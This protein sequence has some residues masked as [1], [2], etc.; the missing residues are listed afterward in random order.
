[1]NL[2]SD[3]NCLIVTDS[4]LKL[5][6]E[7]LL[8]NSLNITKNSKLILTSIP[9]AHGTEPPKRIADE[10]LNYDVVLLA[11]TKSLSHT[12]AR[13]NASKKGARMASMPGITQEMMNRTLNVDFN[14]IRKLNNKLIAKLK[15]KNKIR[16]TTKK[17]TSMVFYLK[18]RK[19]TGDDGIYTKKGSFGNLPA[20]EVF[21]AP[22]ERKSSGKIIVDA[23]I[24]G[25]GKVD[26]NAEL[27]V[28]D[29]FI[30][31]IYGG[32][33]AGKFK[34]L[35][36]GKLYRNVAELGIGTNY[37]ARITGNVLEDEKVAGTCHIAFG[38]NKYF[39]GK[40]DV[41]FHVDVVVKSPTIYADDALIMKDGKI[42]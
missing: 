11:T 13:K 34:K 39:G 23:S 37:R 14:K 25:I 21:I 6:G 33:I 38:N 8:K 18:G 4:K 15:N 31:G 35:L 3:E 5:I 30:S 17:G 32:K 12:R 9:K 10:M 19:W 29:G 27:T 20:G 16:I 40:V 2:K 42:T 1:M 7:S 22:L 26:R 41:P 24:G 36:K 28:K